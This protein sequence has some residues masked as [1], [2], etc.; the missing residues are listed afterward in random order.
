MSNHNSEFSNPKSEIIA[1][2]DTYFTVNIFTYTNEQI[3]GLLKN[4]IIPI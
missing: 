4:K 1:M 2:F 3:W